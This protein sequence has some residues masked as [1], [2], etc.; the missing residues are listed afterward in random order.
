VLS[1]VIFAILPY[2]FALLTP[3]VHRATLLKRLNG[4]SARPPDRE[5]P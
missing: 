3:L 2:A 4:E 5:M 1:P